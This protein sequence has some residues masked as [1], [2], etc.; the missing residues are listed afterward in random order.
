MKTE[1]I[2]VSG[3]TCGGFVA[4]VTLALSAL[5]GVSK[6]DVS[7]PKN[8][9]TVNFDEGRISLDALRS[10]IRAAGYGVVDAPVATSG[11]GGCCGS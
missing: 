11:H 8:V 6:V 4:N 5:S 7:L 2:N 9:A 3:M 1:S 10:A